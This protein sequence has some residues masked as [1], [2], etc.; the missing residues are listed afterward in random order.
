M[1]KNAKV[2]TQG[3]KVEAGEKTDK[4]EP[5]ALA[6]S[7]LDSI[8]RDA[9]GN[10]YHL[11]NA[12]CIGYM[13][14]VSRLTTAMTAYMQADARQGQIAALKDPKA[15]V[16]FTLA[17]IDREKACINAQLVALLDEAVIFC[18]ADAHTQPGYKAVAAIQRKELER[19]FGPIH[20]LTD[21]QGNRLTKAKSGKE[22]MEILTER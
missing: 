9:E 18:G 22:F 4:Q 16:Q 3:T 5:L 21:E 7:R 10:Y 20:T 14:L 1:K 17:Q 2:K 8:I 11:N 12:Q 19:R 15:S 13:S 6:F